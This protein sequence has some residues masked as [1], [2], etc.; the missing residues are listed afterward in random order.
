[1]VFSGL[2]PVGHTVF[3]STFKFYSQFTFWIPRK[4]L[5]EK[6]LLHPKVINLAR[7]FFFTH[8][9]ITFE[10]KF[11][12]LVDLATFAVSLVNSEIPFEG[13]YPIGCPGSRCLS[14]E[15]L[16]LALDYLT[17]N[18]DYLTRN[19]TLNYYF[20]WCPVLFY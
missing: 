16:T 5:G 3:V 11:L 20:K 15:C 14:L 7:A 10:I 12:P 4:F 18:L 2:L 6:N 19:L 1:M 9:I 17:L 8:L 13:F